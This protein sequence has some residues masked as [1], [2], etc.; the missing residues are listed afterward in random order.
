M[1]FWRRSFLFISRIRSVSP[2]NRLWTIVTK[3]KFDFNGLDWDSFGCVKIKLIVMVSIGFFM[4][5]IGFDWVFL[6]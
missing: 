2:F 6:D 4:D 3:R 5:S 1:Y